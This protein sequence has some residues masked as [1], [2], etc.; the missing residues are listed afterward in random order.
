MFNRYRRCQCMY[1]NNTITDNDLIETSCQNA[2]N[3][4]YME[5]NC[6]CGFDSVNDVF[7]SNPM[8]AQSYVPYQFAEETFKPCV[9]LRMGTIYPEL[10]SP[11]Y[12]GQS[13]REIE[14]LRETN[15]IK[16]GCNNDN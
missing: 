11:Y 14:Y 15:E 4:E 8:L 10:V 7:P 12:P 5:N 9:G 2:S 1:N 13:M 3:C 6:Q 16:E